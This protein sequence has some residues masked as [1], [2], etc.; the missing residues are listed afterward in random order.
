M[1]TVAGAASCQDQDTGTQSV[2]PVM[3]GP[4]LSH[5]LQL[6]TAD[7]ITKLK[8]EAEPELKFRH[9]SMRCGHLNTHVIPGPNDLLLTLFNEAQR[10]LKG[11]AMWCSLNNMLVPLLQCIC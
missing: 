8:L 7:M 9:S 4:T 1:L 11:I 5:R 2:F 3:V 6:Q 10:I